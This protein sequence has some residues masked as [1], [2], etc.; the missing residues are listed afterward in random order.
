MNDKNKLLVGF[1]GTFDPLTNGHLDVIRRG[2]AMFD[3]LIV[4][5]GDNPEKKSLLS[6]QTRTE[7]ICE[8]TADLP[9]VSVS[10]YDGLTVEFAEAVGATAILRAIRD[11]ADLHKEFQ[12]AMT[13]RVV[14]SM[15]TVFLMT[16]AEHAFTSSTLIRQIAQMGGDVSALVPPAVLEHIK[17]LS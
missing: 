10:A 14:A 15:E 11:L 5:V 16:A 7:I 8:A 4:G 12:L 6:Q 9:N 17:K 1:P 2:A 13:N 3:E